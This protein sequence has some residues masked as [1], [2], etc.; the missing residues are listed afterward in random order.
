MRLAFFPASAGVSAR[1]TKETFLLCFMPKAYI[2]ISPDHLLGS[3]VTRLLHT[4]NTFIKIVIQ[5]NVEKYRIY[6]FFLRG[7]SAP[8]G[9]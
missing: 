4:V 7:K 1:K 3:S 2:D 5:K 6:Q 9:I 8:P